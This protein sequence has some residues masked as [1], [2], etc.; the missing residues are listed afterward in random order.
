MLEF[1]FGG[2]GAGLVL[3]FSG[4]FVNLIFMSGIFGSLYVVIYFRKM[5]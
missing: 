2:S 3:N 1:V 4:G 5:E